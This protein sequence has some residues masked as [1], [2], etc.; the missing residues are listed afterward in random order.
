[1]LT[2]I[3]TEANRGQRNFHKQALTKKRLTRP[4]KKIYRLS[5]SLTKIFVLLQS[6]CYFR[7]REREKSMQYLERV[8]VSSVFP[9]S[10][11]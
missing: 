2:K 6:I 1:M 7:R 4:N 10:S 3:S 11:S 8:R 5:R 9:S